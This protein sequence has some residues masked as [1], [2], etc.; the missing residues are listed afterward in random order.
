MGKKI[1]IAMDDSENAMRAV[2]FVAESFNPQHE[3]TL[4]SVLPDTAAICEMYSPELTPYFLSQRDAFCSIEEKKRELI[5][6]AMKEA[7]EILLKAGFK[8]ESI[9][10]KVEAQQKGI[11]RDIIDEANSGYDIVVLG[12]RGLS[13]IKEFFLGSVSQK[14][15]NSV[16]EVSVLLVN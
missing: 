12:R 3:I 2:G 10:T 8:K 11:P 15:L 9:R 16:K 1:L 13:G 14:V 6:E 7:I 4:F 5:S